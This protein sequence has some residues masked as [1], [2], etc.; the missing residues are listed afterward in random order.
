[1]ADRGARANDAGRGDVTE[2]GYKRSVLTMRMLISAGLTAAGLALWSLAGWGFSGFDAV[3]GGLVTIYFGARLLG[4]LREI[5]L[6]RPVISIGDDG[7]RD[8]RLGSRT[9]PWTAIAEIRQVTGGMGN[10][11]L[12]LQVSE[13]NRYIGPSKGIL[14]LFYALRSRP[15]QTGFVPMT[16][17]NVLDL[18]EM[19][20]LD[21]VDEYCPHEIPV[22]QTGPKS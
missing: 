16:P 18:G 10:G 21:A 6:P 2:F 9:V 12:F 1:M 4:N 20:L 5:A 11:T 3:L 15:G 17:P 22:A 14:W 8:R 13:P 19:D 7:I